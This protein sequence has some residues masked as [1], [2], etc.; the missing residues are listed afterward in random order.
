MGTS[1]LVPLLGVDSLPFPLDALIGVRFLTLGEVGDKG[2]R[3][4]LE[5]MKTAAQRSYSLQS[6]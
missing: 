5:G 4:K 2:P 1:D 6:K 3:G